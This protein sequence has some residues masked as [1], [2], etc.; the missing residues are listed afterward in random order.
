MIPATDP[1]RQFYVGR[2]Y[3]VERQEDEFVLSV[4]LPFATKE[5]INLSRH[6]D[7]LVIDVGT[8]RRNLVLPRLLVEATTLGAKFD[9][10]VLKIRFAAPPRSPDGGGKRGSNG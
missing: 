1:S 6:A 5:K 3:T 10:H 7:E 9:D 4:E 8:W 2:P